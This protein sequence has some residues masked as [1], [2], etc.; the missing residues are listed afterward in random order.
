MI[1]AADRHSIV[2]AMADMFVVEYTYHLDRLTAQLLDCKKLSR[3]RNGRKVL[4]YLCAPRLTFLKPAA[5]NGSAEWWATLERNVL[6]FSPHHKI[7]LSKLNLNTKKLERKALRIALTV[8]QEVLNAL[9]SILQARTSIP[10]KLRWDDRV[11]YRQTQFGQ[12]LAESHG[13]LGFGHLDYK[14]FLISLC[15]SLL[16]MSQED[17]PVE[18]IL[19]SIESIMPS[20]KQPKVL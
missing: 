8:T 6:T 13:C 17:Y 16:S 7:L 5:E 9:P 1:A 19:E 11:I 10:G 3:F 18:F 20:S 2:C 12:S 15:I 4:K 14:P